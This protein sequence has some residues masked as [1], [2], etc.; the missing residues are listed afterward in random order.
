M[1]HLA[2]RRFSVTLW[3]YP[4]LTVVALLGLCQAAAQTQ[5]FPQ[6]PS[7]QQ[8]PAAPMPAAAESLRPSYELG[9]GDVVQIRSTA[10]EELGERPYRLDATGAITLPLVG[11]VNAIGLTVDQLQT[12][13]NRL[14][15]QYYTNPQVIVTLIQFRA[16]PVFFIG[17]F[18]KPGIYPLQGRRNLV[19]MLSA[20]G[21]LQ[22]TASR[23]IKISRRKEMG[24]IPLP[25]AVQDPDGRGMTVEIP[26]TILTQEINPPEDIELLPYDTITAERAEMVYLSG[27]V[28]KTGGFELGEKESIGI[29]QLLSMAGGPAPDAD[30]KKARI[31]RPVSNTPR[32]A[33]I[34]INLA[35]ALRGG[36]NEIRLLPNDVL[37][38]PP[39]SGARRVL[40]QTAIFIVPPLI[41]TLIW[42]LAA[43]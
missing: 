26:L 40:G 30:L 7:A 4:A 15:R 2:R 32:R 20:V 38:V 13:L 41:T 17:A 37:Y 22:P 12:E 34:P 42:I 29:V 39:R 6:S 10:V 5:S 21:G 23:R 25:T 9:E 28:G 27:A 3:R 43:R 35:Q 19:E 33:E 16:D 8:P 31:L 36:S 18:V 24:D 14:Y 1:N 11:P